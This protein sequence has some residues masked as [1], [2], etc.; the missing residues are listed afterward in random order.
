MNPARQHLFPRSGFTAD[1]DGVVCFCIFGCQIQY[2]FDLGRLC[3]H[4]FGSDA[5]T[6]APQAEE[7]PAP[8]QNQFQVGEVQGLGQEFVGARFHG[9]HGSGDIA[10][11]RHDDHRKIR[12]NLFGFFQK[13]NAGHARHFDIQDDQQLRAQAELMRRTLV[14]KILASGQP[15]RMLKWM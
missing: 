12:F 2:L 11:C 13:V 7:F 4:A 10:E 3:H 5:G 6:Q 9:G 1:Q 15:M 8:V 14:Q